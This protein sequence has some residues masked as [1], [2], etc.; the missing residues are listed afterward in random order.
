MDQ[1]FI[2]GFLIVALLVVLAGGLWIEIGRA[3]V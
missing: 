2:S 1:L 3:H